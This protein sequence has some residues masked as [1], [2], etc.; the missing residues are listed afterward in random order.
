M[1]GT[2]LSRMKTGR[3][4]NCLIPNILSLGF[5][6]R[7]FFEKTNPYQIFIT[8]DQRSLNSFLT[9]ADHS[10]RADDLAVLV[11][12]SKFMLPADYDLIGSAP[13]FRLCFFTVVSLVLR[14]S[15]D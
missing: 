13:F 6:R 7:S 2:M 10:A 1:S 14:A 4:Y 8:V 11:A 3:H 12:Q 5:N 15:C 9:I